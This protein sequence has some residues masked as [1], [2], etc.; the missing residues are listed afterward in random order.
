MAKRTVETKTDK[1]GQWYENEAELAKLPTLIPSKEFV[2]AVLEEAEAENRGGVKSTLRKRRP[3]PD[4]DATRGFSIT[5]AAAKL[6]AIKGIPDHRQYSPAVSPGAML[7]RNTVSPNV[8]PGSENGSDVIEDPNDG[9]YG[10]R[11]TRRRTTTPR[12]QTASRSNAALSKK[13]KAVASTT[14]V[15]R[16]RLG[17]DGPADESEDD[18]GVKDDLAWGNLTRK[19]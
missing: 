14:P 12:K 2:R 19:D 10:K 18:A 11:T 17:M 16:T 7:G 15:K 9:D 8:A 1:T 13:R 6:L 3:R 5:D 4:V